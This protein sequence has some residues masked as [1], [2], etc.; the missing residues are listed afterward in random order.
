VLRV[1]A[2]VIETASGRLIHTPAQT[3]RITPRYVIHVSFTSSIAINSLR[4]TYQLQWH[5]ANMPPN[6]NAYTTIG[7]SDSGYV[8]NDVNLGGAGSGADIAAGQTLTATID[9]FGPK[10]APG[11]THG[12][13]ALR[14]STGPSLDGS[15]PTANIPV[16]T[17]T[18][19]IP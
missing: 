16:G 14:Y 13:I 4:G 1:P 15:F 3:I 5:T 8:S 12:T 10:L 18:V 19:H 17:F 6:V 11:T 7:N 9:P 2:R